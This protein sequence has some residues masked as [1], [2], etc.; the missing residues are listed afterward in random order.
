[1]LVYR[2]ATCAYVTDLS[3]TGARLYGGRWN[4]VGVP[5]VYFASSKP[6]AVLEVLVH[7][8]PDQLQGDYCSACFD[9]PEN[10]ID[11]ISMPDLSIDWKDSVSSLRLK[12]IGKYFIAEKEHLL[13]KVPSAIVEGEYNYLLN[14]LH[15]DV[16]KV[17]LVEKKIFEFDNRLKQ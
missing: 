4:E 17:R 15:P 8:R 9:V 1:M 11:T 14:P 5:M 7:I 16:S 12:Y 3:G 13:L 2:I 6:L 10:S